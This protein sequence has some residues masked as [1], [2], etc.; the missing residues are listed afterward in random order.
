MYMSRRIITEKALTFV[1]NTPVQ[2][3]MEKIDV[4]R[5]VFSRLT[6]CLELYAH[7]VLLY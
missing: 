6:E 5:T 3:L 2:F 1:A 4:S 7:Q